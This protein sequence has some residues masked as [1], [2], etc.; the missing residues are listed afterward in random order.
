MKDF[1]PNTTQE[2]APTRV[3]LGERPDNGSKSSKGLGPSSG[4][5]KDNPHK[6]IRLA[7]HTS[8]NS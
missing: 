2:S 7:R 1:K 4:A 3:K 6:R 8:L 5:Y